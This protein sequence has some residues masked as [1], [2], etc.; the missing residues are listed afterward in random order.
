MLAACVEVDSQVD[1]L[2]EPLK[3]YGQSNELIRAAYS[4]P[5]YCKRLLLMGLTKITY[6]TDFSDED[7]FSF[8]ITAKEWNTVFKSGSDAYKQMRTAAIELNNRETGALWFRTDTEMVGSRWFT[9]VAYP[10]DENKKGQGYVRLK[11]HEDV[12]KELVELTKGG[13][14]TKV[15][16]KAV[17]A[18]ESTYSVRLF[19][20]CRQFRDTGILILPIHEIRRLFCLE[21]KYQAF[22]DLR[23]K[24]IQPAVDEINDKTPFDGRMKWRMK[25][26][27]PKVEQLIFTF[28]REPR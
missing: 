7:A 14:Y 11:F 9:N 4:M 16:L 28:P 15:D 3:Q 5:L 21:N 13:H 26:R 22:T 12:R 2:D 27:G 19:E 18:L 10:L 8:V 20:L 25:K 23:T 17:C 6:S 24:V 1:D